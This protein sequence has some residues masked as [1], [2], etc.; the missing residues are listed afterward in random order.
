MN[1]KR[2]LDGLGRAGILTASK[3]VSQ[4]MGFLSYR[5]NNSNVSP[6][7]HFFHEIIVPCANQNLFDFYATSIF[8]GAHQQFL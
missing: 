4:L 3:Q 1:G 6:D 5:K 8:Y 7:N 2:K